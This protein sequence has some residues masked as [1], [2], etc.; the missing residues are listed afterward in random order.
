[1]LAV[2]QSASSEMV[3]PEW[4]L[5]A[6][7]WARHQRQRW[8]AVSDHVLSNVQAALRAGKDEIGILSNGIEI[9]TPLSKI[10]TEA[11]R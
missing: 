4:H 6:L 5:R 2:F 7:A 3:L 11:L 9:C 1:M 10:E 8:M